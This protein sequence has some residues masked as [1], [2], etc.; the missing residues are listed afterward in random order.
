VVAKSL[1]DR[2]F[3]IRQQ[4][5][6]SQTKLAGLL[7]VSSTAVWNWEQND[8]R[9]RPQMLAKIAQTLGV[10]QTLLLTGKDDRPTKTAAQII[11][12]AKQEIADLNGVPVAKVHVEWRIGN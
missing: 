7:K 9:P 8:V 3:E 4:R 5:G 11:E 6:L 2:I 12:A 10:S 1:G